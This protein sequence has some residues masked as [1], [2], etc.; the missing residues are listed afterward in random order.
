MLL[1]SICE[2][3][4]MERLEHGQMSYSAFTA[5]CWYFGCEDGEHAVLSF[6]ISQNATDELQLY[7]NS[8]P[9]HTELYVTHSSTIS[10]AGPAVLRYNPSATPLPF[11]LTY[12]CS[13]TSPTQLTPSVCNTTQIVL[14]SSG[15]LRYPEDASGKP[16]SMCWYV[17]CELGVAFDVSRFVAVGGEVLEV[18]Q[19]DKVAT[20]YVK[21][22]SGMTTWRAGGATL[23]YVGSNW[24]S[25]FEL[26]YTCAEEPVKELV[27]HSNWP[28]VC[29]AS[30]VLIPQY[31]GIIKHTQGSGC[32]AFS[33]CM[34]PMAFNFTELNGI[35][36]DQ[37]GVFIPSKEGRGWVETTERNR[38]VVLYRP[39][40]AIAVAH[41]AEYS[42]SVAF[43]CIGYTSS[44]A[45]F[46]KMVEVEVEVEGERKGSVLPAVVG[47]VFVLVL[48]FCVVCCCAKR[49]VSVQW[50][51]ESE[52]QEDAEEESMSEVVSQEPR[53]QPPPDLLALP[54]G[55]GATDFAEPPHMVCPISLQLMR[56]PVF[57]G[58][59][60]AKPQHVFE[61]SC[62][63]TH[64]KRNNTCPLSRRPMQANNITP[65]AKL[66]IEIQHYAT[67]MREQDEKEE[68]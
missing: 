54:I 26:S 24:G 15:T 2:T 39:V 18:Y 13:L 21:G 4:K 55:Y 30:R 40:L 68:T 56:D 65:H 10:I 58:C 60:T 66:Q 6:V 33:S 50:E 43:E 5:R 9:H 29:T 47:G 53:M 20:R 41:N 52:L 46:K 35:Y 51:V 49:R 36:P 59:E 45:S 25:R 16:T 37:I 11:N 44:P 1:P 19:G 57:C 64:L 14:P 48:A 61:R 28:D 12:S 42:A 27:G 62:L 63:E 7:S 67:E 34:G 32:W 31:S 17:P 22:T 3:E 38:V 23:H 8:T